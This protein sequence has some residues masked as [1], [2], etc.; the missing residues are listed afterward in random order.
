MR[1]LFSKITDE[2]IHGRIT[3]GGKMEI[4]AIFLQTAPH[5]PKRRVHWLF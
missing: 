4:Q 1:R 2:E 5:F 3:E